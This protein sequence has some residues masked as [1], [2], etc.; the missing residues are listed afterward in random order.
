MTKTN[1]L[2]KRKEARATPELN[3]TEKGAANGLGSCGVAS[4]SNGL[5]PVTQPSQYSG[6][7]L[8]SRL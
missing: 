2:K 1:K 6:L 5:Q 7:V 4:G 3:Q 8:H